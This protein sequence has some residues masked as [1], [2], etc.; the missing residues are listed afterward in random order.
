MVPVLPE[1]E[2]SIEAL[3]SI[4]E[5]GAVAHRIDNGG[6]LYV[7]EFDSPC[8]LSLD[9]R[10]KVLR[11]YTYIAVELSTAYD[12]I[13]FAN[14]CNERIQMVRFAYSN[15]HGRFF[16]TYQL[17]YCT[18]VLRTHILR[19]VREFCGHFNFVLNYE[20]EANLLGV[21]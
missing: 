15:E 6:D 2:V 10:Q 12:L 14:H 20:D 21:T 5:D 16:G 3:S 18:G 19:S 11:F 17:S 8:W 1:V 13:E 9:R 4:L 7:T